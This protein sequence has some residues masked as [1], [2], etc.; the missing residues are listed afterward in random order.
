MNQSASIE[1]AR[2]PELKPMFLLR[3]EDTQAAYVLLYP[4]GVVK[5]NPT[6][7][8]ILRRCDGQR[9]VGELTEELRALFS[10]TPERVEQGVQKFLEVSYAKGWIRDR[11]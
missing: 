7:A 4:E 3:W 2:R 8:E 1:A 6:A 9:T 10:E 11:A 5:L